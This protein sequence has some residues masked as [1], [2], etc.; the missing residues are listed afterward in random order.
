MNRVFTFVLIAVLSVLTIGCGSQKGTTENKTE[1][2]TLQTKDGK[3]MGE[4]TTT[5]DT[6][7]T[8]TPETPDGGGTTIEKTTETTTK[9][10]K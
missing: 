9:T 1:M 10:T 2:K 5:V 7:T 8:T 3:T 4:R 6:K